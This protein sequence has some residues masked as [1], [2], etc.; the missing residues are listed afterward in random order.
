ML[1]RG[2]GGTLTKDGGK[3]GFRDIVN[4]L[5]ARG[6]KFGSID[7][8]SLASDNIWNDLKEPVECQGTTSGLDVGES[9]GNAE[10]V[11]IR[12]TASPIKH[13][14]VQQLMNTYSARQTPFLTV[15]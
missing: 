4:L 3:I 9:L 7:R 10:L 8:V 13:S 6:A 2:N 15:G 11:V 12:S 1:V 14:T 5:Y